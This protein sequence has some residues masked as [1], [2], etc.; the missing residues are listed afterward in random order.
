[1][2]KFTGDFEKLKDYGFEKTNMGYSFS[3]FG[4]VFIIYNIQGANREIFLGATFKDVDDETLE[5]FYD[6]IK[7]G[8]IK[9]CK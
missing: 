4:D 6:L 1:M 9:R 3:S 5:K 8:L 7:D 2:L